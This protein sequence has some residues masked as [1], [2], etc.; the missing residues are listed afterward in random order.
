MCG[1]HALVSQISTKIIQILLG[2]DESSGVSGRYHVER[3]KAS[4]MAR[5]A[6]NPA[7]MGSTKSMRVTVPPSNEVMRSGRQLR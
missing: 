2:R 3:A 7:P 6:A 4:A 1:Q 5:L